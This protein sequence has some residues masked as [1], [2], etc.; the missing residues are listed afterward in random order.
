[1]ANFELTEHCVMRF[2]QRG[3][4]LLKKDNFDLYLELKKEKEKAILSYISQDKQT[5]YYELPHYEGLY[6]IVQKQNMVCVTIKKLSYT[7]KL[8]LDYP[9]NY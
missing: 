9:K 7:E 5:L 6:F 4:N 1:M 3:K 8:N 2:K